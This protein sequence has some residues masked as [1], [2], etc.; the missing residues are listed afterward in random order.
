MIVYR[1]DTEAEI[2]LVIEEL[3]KAGAYDVVLSK[4]WALGSEGSEDLAKAVAKAV[5][6]PSN[7]KFLYDLE[8][9]LKTKIE[10]I[11]KEMYG[12]GNVKYTEVAE[13]KLQKYEEQVSY[14][15]CSAEARN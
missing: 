14:G 13:K 12:A 3:K 1:N 9:P 8:L 5:E 15:I 2:Q 4:H 7:F 10:T 11:A 6:S